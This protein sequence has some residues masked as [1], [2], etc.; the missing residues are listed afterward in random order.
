[1][2]GMKCIYTSGSHCHFHAITLPRARAYIC[3]I[4]DLT[5]LR[6]IIYF[7]SYNLKD[8]Y[9]VNIKPF[10][11]YLFFFATNSL[12]GWWWCRDRRL[13]LIFIEFIFASIAKNA[14]AILCV[15]E[16]VRILNSRGLDTH[17]MRNSINGYMY[18][19]YG[20]INSCWANE[21][22]TNASNTYNIF[23]QSII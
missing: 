17:L 12:S 19:R 18:I 1:M 7:K 14:C 5:H 16:H 11:F 8:K 4:H 10:F 22:G 21:H 13:S 23:S 3:Q 2:R 20:C 9:H 15:D 6:Y